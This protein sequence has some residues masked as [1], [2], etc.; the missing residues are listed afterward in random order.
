MPDAGSFATVFSVFK[1]EFVKD[2]F[3]P[4]IPLSFNV[5]ADPTSQDCQHLPA[6]LSDQQIKPNHLINANL[7]QS[8]IETFNGDYP[9]SV[10]ELQKRINVDYMS[11]RDFPDI[12]NVQFPLEFGT[13]LT[14][15]LMNQLES[16]LGDYAWG[17]LKN[18]I[19][20]WDLFDYD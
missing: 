5:L 12:T 15:D 2:R 16:G 13:G 8:S 1:E 9:L 10:D 18:D 7:Q 14:D 19:K 20:C 4:L 3:A 11:L 6:H 17:S